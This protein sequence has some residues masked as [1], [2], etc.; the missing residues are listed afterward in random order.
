MPELEVMPSVKMDVQDVA[1]YF[2]RRSDLEA[3]DVL[4][5]LKL[6]KLLYYAQGWH[7]ALYG[8]P[9]FEASLEAWEHGPVCPEVW[10]RFK[11]KSW[12]PI[13]P[14]ETSEYP[15]SEINQE[16]M[17]FLSE[18]WD[19]YGQF[20]AKRLEEMTHEEQPWRDAF[21]QSNIQSGIIS[22]AALR[23]FFVSHKK[24]KR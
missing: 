20:S 7:L 12:N 10:K 14:S 19:V 2:I 13:L 17:D 21:D 16:T 1:D 3:G 15:D 8:V 24:R 23:R 11:E 6:Q 9:L 4:T 5:H 22:H 18:V